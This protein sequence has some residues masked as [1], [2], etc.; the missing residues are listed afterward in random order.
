MSDAQSPPRH[1]IS[2]AKV[3]MDRELFLSACRAKGCTTDMDRAKLLGTSRRLVYSYVRGTVV[4][5]LDTARRI[6]GLLEV[7]VDRLWPAA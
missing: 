2:D 5:G 4:P 3:S 1:A 7:D 6:A